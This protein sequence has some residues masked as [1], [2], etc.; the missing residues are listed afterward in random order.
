MQRQLQEYWT[1]LASSIWRITAQLSLNVIGTN[2][3]SSDFENSSR[4]FVPSQSKVKKASLILS[5]S[6]GVR[7]CATPKLVVGK[8][9]E[10]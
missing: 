4:S 2:F 6:S 9:C 8:V 10:V 5:W 1:L 3:V 7:L